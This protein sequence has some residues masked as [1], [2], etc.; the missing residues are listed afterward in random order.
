MHFINHTLSQMSKLS[1]CPKKTFMDIWT[2]P[3]LFQWEFSNI[4]CHTFMDKSWTFGHLDNFILVKIWTF[5]L[6]NIL[7]VHH[8]GILNTN[9]QCS[10][11][12][13]SKD[14]FFWE[15]EKIK[16]KSRNS[17]IMELLLSNFKQKIYCQKQPHLASQKRLWFWRKI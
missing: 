7:V 5:I 8:N 11:A 10:R 12:W 15:K 13:F 16:T 2:N 6:F 3:Q 1:I 17:I 4:E 9:F 14:H